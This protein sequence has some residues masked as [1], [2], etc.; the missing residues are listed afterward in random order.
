MEYSTTIERMI[1]GGDSTREWGAPSGP[2]FDAINH[3]ISCRMYFFEYFVH[4]TY[5]YSTSLQV[6]NQSPGP[7][8]ILSRFNTQT[9]EYT[10]LWS[11][12]GN[13]RRY[14]AMF[15]GKLS[16]AILYWW[17]TLNILM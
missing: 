5:M 2:T 16:F 8:N 3:V 14:R 1:A 13:A 15:S 6:I 9:P 10:A 12:Q 17:A 7:R 11:I 4:F